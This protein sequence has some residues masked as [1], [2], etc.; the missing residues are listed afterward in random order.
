M[1]FPMCLIVTLVMLG[2]SIQSFIQ[3]QWMAGVLQFIIALGFMILLIR[4]ILTVSCQ[5]QKCSTTGCSIPDW[6]T[7]LF[8]KRKN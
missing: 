1:R 2:V 6:F 7:K 4:N 8:K 5:K 3:H